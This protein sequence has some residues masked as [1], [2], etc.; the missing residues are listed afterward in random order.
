MPTMEV[1][2]IVHV[3]NAHQ[4]C[5]S[6]TYPAS[7]IFESYGVE[8]DKKVYSFMEGQKFQD[9]IEKT[10]A[11][12]INNKKVDIT[13]SDVTHCPLELG[14]LHLCTRL[15]CLQYAGYGVE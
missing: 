12:K 6:Q 5:Q 10:E 9:F 2:P 4:S 14:Q 3:D 1:M 7:A 8:A 13:F 11:V 15:M